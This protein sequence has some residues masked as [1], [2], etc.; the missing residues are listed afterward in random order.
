MTTLIKKFRSARKFGLITPVFTLSISLVASHT[1]QAQQ[2]ASSQPGYLNWYP[3][4]LLNE[5]EL[6]ATPEFCSGSYRLSEIPVLSDERIEV[7]ADSSTREKNGDTQFSGDV[8]FKQHNRILTGQHASWFPATESGF[9]SGDVKLRSPLLTLH[10]EKAELAAD[11]VMTFSTAEYAVPQRH[12][13]GSA[14]TLSSPGDGRF[15]LENA[16]LTFCE[17]Q[18]NDWD[19]AASELEIDQNSGVGTAWNARLRVADVPVM[20]LPYYRFPV[21]NQRTTGFLDPQ[22]AVNGQLQAED[23]QLPFYL[24]IAPNLDAT[25]TPHHILDRG[26]AWEGQLRHKTRLFGDG[27]LNLGY[28]GEDDLQQQEYDD[29]NNELPEDA[30]NQKESDERFLINYTQAGRISQHWQ[31]RWQFNKVSDSDYFNDTNPTG[32]VNRA[33]HLPSSGE[34][35]FDQGNWHFD[36]LAESFQTIDDS[37][38]LRDRPYRRLPELDLSYQPSVLNDWQLEQQL[39]YTQF[40]RKDEEEIDFVDQELSGFDALNG[41]RLLSETA[42]SYPM[43][44]PFGF[45]TPKAEYR[46][47]NYEL[48]DADETVEAN[49]NIELNSAHGIGRYSLD[50]GLY[51]DRDF[52]WFNSD[53]QQTLEPRVFWVKSPYLAG[54][55]FI[56]NFDTAERTVTYAT[57]FTGDRFSGG[58]RLAD[59][60]QVSVGLTSRF[61]R[62]DGLEQFRASIGRIYYNEDRRVQLAGSAAGLAELD[63]ESTQATSST[64]GE[65]EWNPSEQLSLYHTLEWDP[66]EDYA[67]QRRYGLRFETQQNRMLNIATN[68]VQEYNETDD[69]FDITTK[70]LDWGFFWA[71]N[72]SWGIVGRQLRDLRSY[73]S[74]EERPVSNVLESLAGFE[75]QNC[76]WRFQM[77]YR[78][79]TSSDNDREEFSTDKRYGF[80]LSIQLK[81]LTTLGGGSDALIE[82]A[83]TGY[84]R[85]NYHDY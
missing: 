57:L 60:D 48:L 59:L 17:P 16:T 26:L 83:V 63:Q 45:V 23:I 18:S 81:G 30:T 73:D 27:E 25:I 85:R 49:D 74:D 13:R 80:I 2:A 28:L 64:L 35:F 84:S 50:A 4:S 46:Y 72:Q 82:D 33:T 36:V 51:F 34:I 52:E 39:Q 8:E 56:P 10:G 24:N 62:D 11:G 3:K 71:L 5:D 38:A 77:L 32:P 42:L 31:H 68:T 15:K 41:R 61:I 37:I 44:W 67:K 19:I 58:D 6:A 69:R 47:R 55:E 22:I 53:Y 43:E 21:G 12:L 79:S 76:C 7:E 65:V 9:F 54:Q 1:A 40:S 66:Y 78:E 14:E 29:F 75:Y 20:Y 70:Q